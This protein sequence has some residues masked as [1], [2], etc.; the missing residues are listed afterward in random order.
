MSVNRR[1]TKVFASLLLVVAVALVAVAIG[2]HAVAA[3]VGAR[4]VG[5]IAAS[6]GNPNA[7]P[8]ILRP[9]T[10]SELARIRLVEAQEAAAFAYHPPANARYSLAEMNAYAHAGR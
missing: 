3:G 7:V 5:S 4:P 6:Q 2:V 9:A 10:A 8:P 1:T